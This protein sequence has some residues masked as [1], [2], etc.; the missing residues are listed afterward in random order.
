MNQI[1]I[2]NQST[3]PMVYQAHCNKHNQQRNMQTFFKLLAHPGSGLFFH[4]YFCQD[5]CNQDTPAN[6]IAAPR[7]WQEWQYIRGCP[8]PVN[9]DNTQTATT[10]TQRI[11]T[12][13]AHEDTETLP[14]LLAGAQC[15][16]CTI[17]QGQRE[18]G[19]QFGSIQAPVRAIIERVIRKELIC[20]VPLCTLRAHFWGFKAPKTI[21]TP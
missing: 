4:S 21:F 1:E 5:S 8:E 20:T 7:C 9:L 11:G 10:N 16:P 2:S 17:A 6:Y 12:N 18:V 19:I 15:T 13:I 3:L 14:Q